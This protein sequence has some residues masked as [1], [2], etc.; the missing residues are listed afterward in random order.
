MMTMMVITMMMRLRALMTK[1]RGRLLRLGLVLGG[2]EH[3][4]EEEEDSELLISSFRSS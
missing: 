2:G 4:E 1:S 3:Q